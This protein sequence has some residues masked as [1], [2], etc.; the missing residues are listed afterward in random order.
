VPTV[1]RYTVSDPE[2]GLIEM[3]DP[4]PPT[5]DPKQG[6]MKRMDPKA[7]R[8]MFESLPFNHTQAW[9][10]AHAERLKQVIASPTPHTLHPT[11]YTLHPTPCTLA[12]MYI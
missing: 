7:F 12:Y 6:T 4:Q 1:F 11:P 5:P 8:T 2:E 3:A 10:G 9:A